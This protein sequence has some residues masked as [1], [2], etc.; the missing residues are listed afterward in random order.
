MVPPG[1]A[2]A[3]GGDFLG[4]LADQAKGMLGQLGE[5]VGQGDKWAIGGIGAAVGA[6]LSGGGGAARGALGGAATALLG[7]LAYNALKDGQGAAPGAAP[8]GGELP[9]GVRPPQTPAE[10]ATL[11]QHA[12]LALQAMITAAKADGRIDDTERQR[13]LGKLNEAGADPEE[14]AFVEAELAKPMD[15]DALVAAVPDQQ[16]AA[17]IYAASLLAISVDTPAEKDYM[18]Q[19]AQ[20][21]GLDQATVAS[22]HGRLG[23]PPLA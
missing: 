19:L 10:E 7:M 22:L 11:E 14:Q 1:Q 17:E 9:L 20:R 18:Q 8:A 3:G 5:R 4:G 21:L 15:L 13:I 16:T 6:L 23:A 12:R 2:A